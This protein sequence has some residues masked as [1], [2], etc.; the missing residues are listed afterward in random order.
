MPND[1]I[2]RWKTHLSS[3]ELENPAGFVE[4]QGSEESYGATQCCSSCACGSATCC[5]G[6]CLCPSAICSGQ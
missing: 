6:S 3:C 5:C 4:L 1:V 2:A